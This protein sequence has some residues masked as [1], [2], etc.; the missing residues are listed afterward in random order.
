MS[1]LKKRVDALEAKLAPDAQRAL[2]IAA[3]DAFFKCA[4]FYSNDPEV[5]AYWN[6]ETEPTAEERALAE[7]F[8]EL[9]PAFGAHLEKIYGPI[10]EQMMAEGT[11]P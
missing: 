4:A 3:G 8:P 6:A 10:A 7:R 5:R 9:S 1:T 11:L 2:R